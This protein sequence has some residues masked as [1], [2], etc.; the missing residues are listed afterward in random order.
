M[1][2][3]K[4]VKLIIAFILFFTPISILSIDLLKGKESIKAS[5]TQSIT[6]E[7]N[8]KII[9]KGFIYIKKPHFIKWE[10]F[11]PI[12][13][14]IYINNKS[15]I[16]DEPELEQVSIMKIN[17]RFK[18]INILQKATKISKN[19]Y[20]SSF[21][22]IIYYISVYKGKIQQISF[23]DYLDNKVVIKLANNKYNLRLSNRFF[24]FKI[25]KNYDVIR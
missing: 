25:P 21:D 19:K 15:I 3:L 13:K 14:S 5:F 10:Y 4:K 2:L 11:S 8:N 7:N 16:I 20:K 23:K 22:N 9:Y 6:Y 12:K 17:K 1:L 24:N 18:I